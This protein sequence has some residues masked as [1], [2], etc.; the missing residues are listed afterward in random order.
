[1]NVVFLSPNFP[2]Q[3]PLFCA[4]LRAQGVKVLGIGDSPHQALAPLLSQSLDEYYYVPDMNRA[5]EM[6]RALGYLT[7]RHGRID[8]IDSLNEYWLDAEARLRED[9]NIPGPRPAEVARWRSKSGMR[10]IFQSA[11]VPCTEGERFASPEQVRAFARR[12]GF[13]LVFKP[14]VGVGAAWTFQVS[15][16]RELDETLSRELPVPNYVVER[17]C[18]GSLCTYDGLTDKDGHIVFAVS[19]AYS[20]GVMQLVNQANDL[21]YYTRR[22]IPPRLEELGRKTVAAFGLRERF[23]HIEF[24]EEPDGDYRALEVNVRPPGGFT[25]DMV[26]YTCDF[27]VYQ[28]WARALR[29]ESLAPFAYERKYACAHIARRSGRAYR[30][31][32]EE[33]RRRLGEALLEIREM[34]PVFSGVMGNLMYLV[35]FRDEAEV[36]EAARIIQA[37][38]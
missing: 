26:N 23:F 36:A 5:E 34:P 9:F 38:P 17:F 31:S 11:G 18:R 13:P 33:L 28:L 16:E 6:G 24:F 30:H 12:V 29:G 15:D 19:L 4:A 1:V 8:R 22:D 25:T 20:S 35:R 3:Y 7:W 14:D 37:P 21:H 27:D 32:D 10:E 2:P